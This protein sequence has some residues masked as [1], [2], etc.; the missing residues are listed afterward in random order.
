MIKDRLSLSS[1]T[2]EYLE[3]FCSE[4]RQGR[5]GRLHWDSFLV[6]AYGTQTNPAA[7]DLYTW[8]QEQLGEAADADIEALIQDYERVG[9]ILESW[10]RISTKVRFEPS[11]YEEQRQRLLKALT[12]EPSI[13]GLPLGDYVPSDPSRGPVLCTLPPAMRTK[14]PNQLLVGL[15]NTGKTDLMSRMLIHDIRAEDRAVVAIDVDGK[16]VDLVE[17]WARSQPDAEQIL[18]RFVIIDPTAGKHDWS[19]N[20]LAMPDNGDLQSASSAVVA[21]F[22]AIY[23]EPPGSQSQWNQ[24]TANILRSAVML[25]MANGKTLADLVTLLTDNDF[26]DILLE[27][28]ERNRAERPEYISVLETWAQYK[29]LARTNQWIV[30]VEPILNRVIPTLSDPRIRPILTNAQRDLNFVELILSKKILLVKLPQRHLNANA[31]LL[32]SLIITSLKQVAS[33]LGSTMSDRNRSVALYIDGFENLISNETI[34]LITDNTSQF[35]LGL[36][37]STRKLAAFGRNQPPTA[38]AP[39]A[40]DE[41]IRMLTCFGSVAAFAVGKEDAQ[42]LAAALLS[43][44]SG[45]RSLTYAS[46]QEKLNVEMFA[47]QEPRSYIWSHADTPGALLHLRLPASSQ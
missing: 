1:E 33:Y 14:N 31:V 26:R 7:V 18:Q 25:L 13:G 41:M 38:N 12:M 16:L 37:A 17:G 11:Q 43:P 20:P 22:K 4:R 44:A 40:A 8:L 19:F 15:K 36:I 3:K 39:E 32:G 6:Y 10:D 27:E 21:G 34:Q 28:V 5:S 24:Q 42:L 46:D 23:K 35:E 47:N 45:V 30:W 9:A 29:K 2:R